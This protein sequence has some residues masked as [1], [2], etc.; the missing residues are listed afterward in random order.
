[1]NLEKAKKEFDLFVKQYD[2]EFPKMQ[3]KYKHSYRVMENSKNIA[4]SLN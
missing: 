4:E 2:L 3:R 1:M